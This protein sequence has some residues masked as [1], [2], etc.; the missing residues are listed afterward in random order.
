MLLD[1]SSLDTFILGIQKIR[2]RF[3]TIDILVNN[4]GSSGPKQPLYQLPTTEQEL[5]AL[6]ESE[7]VNDALNSLLGLP[8][9]VTCGLLPHLA[10]GASIINVS[11]IFSKTPY[12][13]RSAY[14]VP[15]A[16]LNALSHIM[17]EELGEL[18]FCIRVNTLYPGPVESERIHTVLAAMDKLKGIPQGTTETEISSSMLLKGERFVEKADIA[19]ALVFLGSSESRQFTRHDFEV[20]RGLITQDQQCI[21]LS[22]E[23][24]P[25]IV[26]LDGHFTWVVGGYDFESALFL[27]NKHYDKNAKIL[28]SLRSR[29]AVK[30]AHTLFR[31]KLNFD[32]M[33]FD[34]TNADDW[35]IIAKQFKEW[36]LFPSEIFVFPHHSPKDLDKRFGDTLSNIPIEKIQEF[37]VNEI[38]DPMITARWLFHISSA[39]YQMFQK[40]ISV[41][42]ISNPSDY[43]GNKFDRIRSAAIEQLIRIWRDEEQFLHKNKK[44]K[45]WQLLRYGNQEPNNLEFMANTALSLSAH[46][47]VV[48]HIT[49]SIC[50][51]TTKVP[52]EFTYNQQYH[53][54]LKDLNGT[55]TILTGGSEGI[56]REITRI[57]VQGGSFVTIASRNAD[58][59]SKTKQMLIKELT[60]NGFANAENRIFT[61]TFDASRE[62]TIERMFEEVINKCGRIDFLVNNAG[63]SGEEQLVIDMSIEGWRKT[64]QANLQS[65]YDLILRSL[66]YM[67][68]Q[69]D[70]HIVNISSA[71]GGMKNET[72]PYPLRADY[73]VAKGGQRALSESFALILGPEVKINTV[74]PGPVEGDRV[75]GSGSRPGLYHRRALLNAENRRID[76]LYNIC[77][78]L[79]KKGKAI[80]P[81]LDQLAVNKFDEFKELQDLQGK[82]SSEECSSNTRVMTAAIAEKLLRRL[83]N[84][85]FI[86]QNYV[87]PEFSVPPEPFWSFEEINANATK[88]REN[89]M[90][91]LALKRMP[92]EYDVAREVV[93]NLSG[94]SMTGETLYPSCGIKLENTRIAGD[95]LSRWDAR[96]FEGIS[97][98]TVLLSGSA[99]FAEMA[100]I[101]SAYLQSD[102]VSKV[103]ICIDSEIGRDLVRRKLEEKGYNTSRF[104]I[105]D[106]IENTLNPQIMISFPLQS[107]PE[108]SNDWRDLPPLNTFKEIVESH[109]TNHF[110]LA[111]K[112]IQIDHCLFFMVTHPAYEGCGGM[113]Q[114][115]SEFLSATL[116]PFT[117]TVGAE[118]I[119]LPHKAEFYQISSRKNIEATSYC[120]KLIATLL[121]LSLPK[122]GSS[123]NGQVFRL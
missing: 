57:L 88:I 116:A 105:A 40:K 35:R 63:I 110:I 106:K 60:A 67:K 92:T 70:G 97:A 31:D 56:G 50:A 112:A 122:Q 22:V 81:F 101:A 27:A 45:V 103:F 115:F 62:E 19:D 119:R 117:V 4:A 29:E 96:L 114:A 46:I 37:L 79:W 95:A 33:Y 65:N 61:T 77:I 66:P 72:P 98:D 6:G 84:G 36:M 23:P 68:A 28:L 25:R 90:K 93:F 52:M 26:D 7:T 55:V 121:L 80:S 86:D 8:W 59:I 1:T 42:F 64:L 107:L 78:S 76:G 94:Q 54:M 100:A 113:P 20:T 11:T 24:N 85:R 32:V 2:S 44:T 34:P 21:E 74:S 39:C 43:K 38:A 41:I 82:T 71:F 30:E 48:P 99:M 49:L 17:A 47:T 14:V 111:K 12:F 18:P 3:K 10:P 83:K 109:L 5:Q 120:Q 51:E 89:I 123:S 118:S 91:S 102:K 69:Q 16:A 15:K 87:F 13:G 9:L 75:R 53:R 58:K 104:T 108:G 73:A